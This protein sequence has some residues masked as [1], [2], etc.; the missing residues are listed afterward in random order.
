MYWGGQYALRYQDQNQS[1]LRFNDE[2]HTEDEIKAALN[3]TLEE[4]KTAVRAEVQD[5]I[6][7]DGD[8]G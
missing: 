7:K 6:D 3:S 1:W 8:I 5:A 2:T 4:K